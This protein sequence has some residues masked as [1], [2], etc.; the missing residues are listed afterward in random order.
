MRIA[1][2]GVG[3]VGGYFGGRLAAAGG[4]VAFIARGNHL[5]ALRRDGLRVIS[6]KGDLLVH[7]VAATADPAE[8]GPVDLILFSVK[9][10]DT[11]T[12]A[13]A[14]KPM[15]GPRTVVVTF[16]NG[17]DSVERIS[18]VVGA[19]HVAG[20][21]CHI[22]AAIAAP[23]IIRHTGTL[24]RLTVGS[25][26]PG[27]DANL[28][29]FASL[30][31]RAGIEIHMVDDVKRAIWEKF[32]FLAPFSGVTTLA[33][34]PIGPI[35]SDPDTRGLFADAVAEAVAVARA[36][37]VPLPDDQLERIMG[38]TDGL[39]GEMKSSM[40]GDLERGARL[41]LP[42]LSGAVVQRAGAL[43]IAAPVHR[44]IFA[45]LKLHAP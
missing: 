28:A 41:E 10:W 25:L 19:E 29:A 22:A 17:V 13:Q 40:L 7:P 18:S 26:Y 16:Q 35:R 6:A 27:Q 3:G 21:V 15:I 34:L 1:V 44:V 36:S 32:I 12:A 5:E 31:E 4:D 45:A 8:I 23:G 20:G 39:P 43:G 14:L 24:A 11:E 9:L 2:M 30:A 37:G 42:W 33:R 38:F